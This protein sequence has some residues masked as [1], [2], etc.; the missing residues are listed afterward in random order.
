M[1]M[2]LKFLNVL[3]ECASSTELLDFTNTGEA[4]KDIRSW[5]KSNLLSN[6]IFND[7][8]SAPKRNKLKKDSNATNN[9]STLSL[10]ISTYENSIEASESDPFDGTKECLKQ[11]NSTKEN[12]K[13][14]FIGSISV[15]QNPF[16]F[17]R[18]QKESYERK[19][20]ELS[21]YKASQHLLNPNQINQ[22][23][24][25]LSL[26]QRS[27]GSM[28][29][30]NKKEKR[31]GEETKEGEIKD[32]K[33]SAENSKKQ[34]N[35]DLN[36]SRR[37]DS[38]KPEKEESKMKEKE[39]SKKEREESKI[40]VREEKDDGRSRKRRYTHSSSDSDDDK[41]GKERVK[42]SRRSEPSKKY[43]SSSSTKVERRHFYSRRSNPPPLPKVDL[44]KL[45]AGEYP[46][47]K[48]PTKWN[49]SFDSKELTEI[50]TIKKSKPKIR[51]QS[52]Q[53]I[54]ISE[55]SE[56]ESSSSSPTKAVKTV[57]VNFW[58]VKPPFP[59]AKTII[60]TDGTCLSLFFTDK[61]VFSNHFPA[62]FTVNGMLFCFPCNNQ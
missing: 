38:I 57:I 50:E 21:Q 24:S 13:Q 15:I 42:R 27:G 5:N 2:S 29:V 44:A 45:A 26:P 1:F 40:K 41:D 25:H 18:Q 31:N 28:S 20:P 7:N 56:T 46:I 53:P 9:C 11:N 32:K 58:R 52:P 23:N 8:Y 10:H 37:K 12:T 16:E 35:I 49:L 4:K 60:A 62:D 43:E 61:Y 47:H 48:I 36:K 33:E 51:M 17:P 6:Y 14:I 59:R 54:P 34:R 22:I 3:Y 39:G 55:S 30:E 19:R